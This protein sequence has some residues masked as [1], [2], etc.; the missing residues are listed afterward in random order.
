MKS[1]RSAKAAIPVQPSPVAQRTVESL[2]RAGEGK[3]VFERELVECARRLISLRKEVDKHIPPGLVKDFAWDILLELFINGEEGG[4]VYVKQLMLA[5]GA[6][7]TSA[8]R[9]IDRLEDEELIE[10][11]PDPLDH[12]RVIVGLSERGRNAM[13]ALLRKVLQQADPDNL[14]A[15]PMP[16]KPR[17]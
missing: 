17:R 11:A 9:L 13:I 15:R 8:M 3:T 4:I 6:T 1:S 7:P 16:Y 2:A 5:S 14:T 12:R 10:R